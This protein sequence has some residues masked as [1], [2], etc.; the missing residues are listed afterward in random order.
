MIIVILIIT[1]IE[2]YYDWIY[3]M[4]WGLVSLELWMSFYRVFN[5]FIIGIL[6]GIILVV[7]WFRYIRYGAIRVL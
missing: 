6:L 3:G 7:V 4:K 5:I 2:L 1:I